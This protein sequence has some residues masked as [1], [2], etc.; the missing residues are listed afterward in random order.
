MRMDSNKKAPV[1]GMSS[2]FSP[3]RSTVPTSPATT[4]ASGDAISDGKVEDMT[5]AE[6][7]VVAVEE[8]IAAKLCEEPS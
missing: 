6:R 7:F 2:P 5:S 8:L 4:I 1:A 3:P